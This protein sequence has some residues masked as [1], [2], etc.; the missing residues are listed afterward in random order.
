MRA[1]A[2]AAAVAVA[3][4]VVKLLVAWLLFAPRGR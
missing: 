4:L 3:G 1:R 2:V